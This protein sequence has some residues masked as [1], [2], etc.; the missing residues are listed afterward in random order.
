[1]RRFSAHCTLC[2]MH[3]HMCNPRVSGIVATGTSS[4][5]KKGFLSIF[6]FAQGREVVGHSKISTRPYICLFVL[7][8]GR[9]RI[10]LSSRLIGLHGDGMAIRASRSKINGCTQH[11]CIALE[12]HERER[13]PKTARYIAHFYDQVLSVSSSLSFS[14]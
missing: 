12:Y 3:H 4:K 13:G 14:R 2:P 8:M 1:M 9:Q 7:P 5:T 11:P 10:C 6:V